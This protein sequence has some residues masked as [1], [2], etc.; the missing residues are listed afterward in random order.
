MRR[1]MRIL[2]TALG[3][4]AVFAN[5]VEADTLSGI[6]SYY[7]R[8]K[9]NLT[10][11]AAYSTAI[12]GYY[13]PAVYRTLG[14]GE[15][16][17]SWSDKGNDF[18][19]MD[20]WGLFVGS[21]HIGF[22]A[23]RNVVPLADGSE[24]GVNDLR[25][26]LAF[27]D[28]NT[29]VGYGLGWSTGDKDLAGR[30]TILQAG[31]VQ[32]FG[33]YVSMGLV[34]T[35]AT[36]KAEQSGVTDLAVRPFGTSALT[37]FADGELPKGVSVDNAPWSIGAMVQPVAGLQL[38]GR[39][40]EDES[41]SL[42]IGLSMGGLGLRGTPSYDKDNNTIN[43]TYEIRTG[44]AKR[45]FVVDAVE[46]DRHYLKL[47]MKGSVTYR[48]FKYFDSDSH[49]LYELLRDL[50]HARNDRSISGIVIHVGG[51]RVSH[52][53]AWEI[54]EKLLELQREGKHVVVFV[55]SMGMTEF[56]LASVAD[57]IVMDPEG[58]VLIPGYVM[59]RTFVKDMLTKLG[60]GFDEWR[61]FKYKSAVEPFSRTT[62]S[63]A[64]K[65]QRYAIIEDLYNTVRRDVAAGRNVSEERVDQW[66]N[67]Q[68]FMGARE[69]QEL[70]LVDELG[71]W[72]EVDDVI[73]DVE[74]KKKHY[75]S[76]GDLAGNRYA[77]ETWG[78]KRQIALVYALGSCSMD[79][80]INARRLERI[81]R[82]LKTDDDVKAVVLRVDSPGGS[83]MASDVVAEQLKAIAKE[84]PV[85]VSQGDVAASGGYWLSMYA[86]SIFVLPATITGSIGV[87]GAWVWDDGIGEK[88]GHT[89][90]HVKVGKRADY[91]AGIR[92]LLF[93]PKLPSRNLPPESRKHVEREM[94]DFYGTFLDK[95]SAGRGI[96]RDQV[97]RLAQGRV[98]SGID[99]IDAGLVD[100]IGGLDAAIHAARAAAGIVNDDRT[101]VVEY[102]EMPAFDLSGLRPLSFLS[103]TGLR[104]EP[105]PLEGM[106][107]PEGLEWTYIRTLI[108]SPGRPLIMLPPEY[109]IEDGGLADR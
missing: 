96:P 16:I 30:S 59:G 91:G 98:Y 89:S 11:P 26:A 76:T 6:P 19:S 36:E 43:S 29:T 63:E 2:L 20:E 54:R 24:A 12:G 102:P 41:Y 71:R 85:I 87:I 61:F 100:A 27:G 106:V 72:D 70:G 84:K 109:Y 92:F 107:V 42:S 55:E 60:V 22:G 32:R 94:L 18:G 4:A 15:F 21:K 104:A 83:P 14:G 34:G 45:S 7:S 93:G 88:I 28:R 57:R 3:A 90:D 8:S 50:E 105:D 40:F 108:D 79:S 77:D 35:F 82:K 33:R 101:E 51:M 17:F 69:A 52:G 44:Y 23:V 86:D 47:R 1:S 62:M 95:V 65:E 81:L 74:G 78:T 75:V 68:I 99:G 49:P 9:F 13:N 53:K 56:H 103:R 73:K 5:G 80:G 39:Y 31:L 38:I 25:L 10:S 67:E 66:I 97:D 46:K 37:V 64:D 48:G 58:I